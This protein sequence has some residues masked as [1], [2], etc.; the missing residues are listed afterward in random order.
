M[1]GNTIMTAKNSFQE[2]LIMDFAPD[3][4]QAN[5]L[6]SALNA[7]LLTFNGNEMSLQNDMGNGR[8]E[9]AYLPEGYVPVGTCE[10][11]DIIYIV[12]Y[13]PLIDKAQIGCFPSPE[14]NISSEELH[15]PDVT[16]AA[17]DFQKL[18]DKGNP[19]G[20]LK[21]SS[22][23]KILFQND[24][25]PG[26]K[27][28]VYAKDIDQTEVIETL[29][30]HGNT[31][32]IMG[33]FPKFVKIRI[34]S[35]EESGKMIY[36]DSNT[37]WYNN[38]YYIQEGT[39]G[40]D[41]LEPDIDSY[42]SLVS[43]AYNTF[44]SKVSGK[45]ALLIELEKITGFS[46]SWEVYET[47]KNETDKDVDN[48][49][50]I[51][52]NFS[53]TTD[54]NYIN[55]S[56]VCLTNSYWTKETNDKNSF[57]YYIINQGEKQSD[58]WTVGNNPKETIEITR[59]YMPEG[60]ASTFSLRSTSVPQSY[61]SVKNLYS[62]IDVKEVKDDVI[63]NLYN[64]PIT[65][66]FWDDLKIPVKRN[67]YDVD[68]TEAV[69]NYEITP[70][71]PYGYLREFSQ[72]G[73]I[74]FSK[75][76][77][78]H[79][80]LHTWKYY[81]TADTCTL[82]WGM[83]AYT[84]PGKVVSKV[85][86][87]FYD[88]KGLVATLTSDNKRS[89]NG[90]FTEYFNFNSEGSHPKLK[91]IERENDQNKKEKALI[92]SNSL[93]LVKI[94][95]YQSFKQADGTLQGEDVTHTECR[96][97]WTNGVFNKYYNQ[98]SD[99]D[100]LDLVLDLD[101]TTQFS[102]NENWKMTTTKEAVNIENLDMDNQSNNIFSNVQSIQSDNNINL[103]LTTTLQNNYNTFVLSDD[104][105][106]N[107][108]VVLAE[109]SI[110]NIPEQPECVYTE[111][112]GI[113]PDLIPSFSVTN[114]QENTTY[115]NLDGGKVLNDN[116][117]NFDYNY[118]TLEGLE[119]TCKNGKITTLVA[120]PI[121]SNIKL[122]FKAN[123]YSNYCCVAGVKQ[124]NNFI[125][126][127][128]IYYL[129]DLQKYGLTYF[130]EYGFYFNKVFFGAIDNE[131]DTNKTVTYTYNIASIN[132]HEATP[133]QII[134]N[135]IIN[136]TLAEG[137]KE[138]S[139]GDISYVNLN[140]DVTK[141]AVKENLPLFFPFSIG[142]NAN[143]LS[144]YGEDTQG[145]QKNWTKW[146][147]KAIWIPYYQ[148]DPETG[149]YIINNSSKQLDTIL[150][151][152]DSYTSSDETTYSGTSAGGAL[153]L[154]NTQGDFIVST[155]W[156]NEAFQLLGTDVAELLM[157]L[158]YITDDIETTS[159]KYIKSLIYLKENYTRYSRDIVIDVMRYTNTNVKIN[160]VLLNT[161]V[162]NVEAQLSSAISINS[163]NIKV[164]F[165]SLRKVIP[166]EF[167][168]HYIT[169]DMTY[170]DTKTKTKVVSCYEK[171]NGYT[172]QDLSPNQIYGVQSAEEGNI[173]L[174]PIYNLQKYPECSYV[175]VDESGTYFSCRLSTSEKILTN[176][177]KG[178]LIVDNGELCV[179]KQFSTSLDTFKLKTCGTQDGD[180]VHITGFPKNLQLL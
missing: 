48:T 138:Y 15:N 68:L 123:H 18:D 96:W 42:R 14:R 116:L 41:T 175:G 174:T 166:V 61:E 122:S 152:S 147:N 52:F 60:D 130:D 144:E 146:R 88:D 131:Y 10:F 58:S 127:P 121:E 53:W 162:D 19:T 25:H 26:D 151:T 76:G 78:E 95:I 31:D 177:L 153:A 79:I 111:Y 40:N 124:I 161:Y 3:N 112:S 66:L 134:Q 140:Q 136:N 86:F 28:I 1:A 165:N 80:K 133:G 51:Y 179:S 132:A 6:T 180:N 160:N 97:F 118:T 89:Y 57:N 54:S 120:T 74:D 110:Q 65:K 5:C 2:G 114:N 117:H 75:I 143:Q 109:E 164:N 108:H 139:T 82:T 77:K 149:F 44:A 71:M 148:T 178:L 126:K 38:N 107:V 141:T 49:Y 45:L 22:I 90:I 135:Y 100:K 35:I 69:Y 168:I 105:K 167:N 163:N 24:L 154:R 46:H 56:A 34:V 4:T 113:N 101:V 33:R 106:F 62:N 12:S 150:K 171:Y 36:I 94:D 157:S 99:F 158:Y 84:S 102:S 30:D 21:T 92:L 13:N 128:F 173:Q 159:S 137:Y 7:T 72:K 47:G 67:D 93:Y 98:V 170:V 172:T 73:Q 142:Y 43:S 29:S 85:V 83:D 59:L 50:N 125:V 176:T 104:S 119:K 27:Y 8:V 155:T 11:G 87:S 156:Q 16:L 64:Q 145:N 20:E 91:N 55:L 39:E 37:K 81:N 9:T 63:N 129:S 23:K 17:S 115:M 70:A 169:P 32:H 103:K